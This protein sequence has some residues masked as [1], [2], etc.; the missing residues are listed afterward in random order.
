M[1]G[2]EDLDI[3][4]SVSSVALRHTALWYSYDAVSVLSDVITNRINID[5]KPNMWKQNGISPVGK[6]AF[7]VFLV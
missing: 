1:Y 5:K 6:C 4:L 2:K 7:Y 3:I